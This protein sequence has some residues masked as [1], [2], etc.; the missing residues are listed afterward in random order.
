MDARLETPELTFEALCY[1]FSMFSV[2]V[3]RSAY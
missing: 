1:A 3:T 2:T